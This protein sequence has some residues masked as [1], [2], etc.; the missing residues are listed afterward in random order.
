M[1]VYT[2][3]SGENAQKFF[4]EIGKIKS[5]KGI[6]E[7]V[8]N[9]NYKV[10]LENGDKY[11]LTIFEKRTKK[12]D[13]PFFNRSMLEF[14]KN[15]IPCPTA[16]EINKNTIFNF[17]NKNCCIYNFLDGRPISKVNNTALESLSSAIARMHDVGRMTQINRE[18]TMLI[19]SWN[20]ILDKFKDFH[21]H[22]FIQEIKL[23]SDCIYEIQNQFPIDLEKSLIHADLFPD[24]IFFKNNKV[25]GIIDFFFTC[26]DT[27]IYDLSTLINSWFFNQNFKE[28]N[29][30]VF[31]NNYLNNTSLR[32]N[33]KE[34]LNFYLKVSAIR[35]F[36]TRLHDMYFNTSGEVIHKDPMEFFNI[37]RF[38]Q[39]NNLRDLI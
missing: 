11:I 27:V 37:L 3:I 23:V 33:E 29:C 21:N 12:K 13:L 6:Q 17:Q 36:L 7:G 4:N 5:L 28:N 1:A 25:S 39:S 2:K 14:K 20:Y 32:Q 24:N 19:P 16:I 9:T 34:H 35:F 26:Q 38:H 31:L 8:E 22:K 15:G 10:I 30:T 18:N